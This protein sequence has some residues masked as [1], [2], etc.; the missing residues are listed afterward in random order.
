M[1]TLGSNP[2]FNVTGMISVSSSF[3][4]WLTRQLDIATIDT[5]FTVLLGA[6]SFTYLAMQ[7][8]LTYLR[9]KKEKGRKKK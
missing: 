2:L 9:T 3:G 1:D 5:A 4:L 8:Y 6:M 7:I